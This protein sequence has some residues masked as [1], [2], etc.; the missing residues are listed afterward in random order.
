MRGMDDQGCETRGRQQ[1]QAGSAASMNSPSTARGDDVSGRYRLVRLGEARRRR[2]QRDAPPQRFQAGTA[3][4]GEEGGR[5]RGER[6]GGEERGR[7]GGGR[8]RGGKGGGG[9]RRGGGEGGE[10]EG[11]GG[12]GGGGEGGRGGREERGRGGGRRVARIIG[13]SEPDHR[14]APPRTDDPTVHR[15]SEFTSS[16]RPVRIARGR[17]MTLAMSSSPSTPGMT[18]SCRA[19][20]PSG[21]SDRPRGWLHPR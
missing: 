3:G 7:R 17:R 5:E 11:G 8:G 2:T 12:K 13:S 18:S 21:F 14:A 4:G 15:P 16:S 20:G 6:G 9:G 19:P 10:G 1:C